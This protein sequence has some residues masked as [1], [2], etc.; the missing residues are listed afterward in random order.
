MKKSIFLSSAFSTIVLCAVLS[1]QATHCYAQKYIEVLKSL[2]FEAPKALYEPKGK[3]AMMRMQPSTNGAK[4]TTDIGVYTLRKGVLIGDIGDNPQWATTFIDGKKCYVSKS[5]LKESKGSAFTSSMFNTYAADF[6]HEME[7]MDDAP[8]FVRWRLQ[9]QEGG[10]NFAL[11]EMTIAEEEYP[12]DP[13]T[14]LML[15]KRVG[16]IFVFKYKVPINIEEWSFD[17]EIFKQNEDGVYLLGNKN[18][19]QTITYE[20]GESGGIFKVPDYSKYTNELI[21]YLFHNVIEQEKLSYFYLDSNRFTP[22][23]MK[24][25][26]NFD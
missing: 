7:D 25:G 8:V 5:V 11:C 19:M 20:D 12:S 17:K 18:Y 26:Y 4:L 23:R 13:H 16:D 1:L 24:K 15:G 2:T 10:L 14:Y 3:T 9:E 6:S 21:Y 22:L